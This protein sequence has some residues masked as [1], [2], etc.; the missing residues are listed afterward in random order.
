MQPIATL[1]SLIPIVAA[2]AAV[3][4]G[5]PVDRSGKTQTGVASYYGAHHAGKTT[6][7]GAPMTPGSLTAASPN[8]PLGAKAKVTNRDTG[9]SVQVT[10]TDRGPYAK[11]RILDVSTKA[12]EA[13]GMKEDG[14]APVTVDPVEPAPRP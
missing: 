3:A 13:L 9:K 6:A 5:Q 1:A 8:L 12:A 11:G 2:T 4:G 7:S 10:V 14:V